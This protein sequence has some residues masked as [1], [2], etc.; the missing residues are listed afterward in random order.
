[1]C[2]ERPE[3]GQGR[4]DE[5]NDQSHDRCAHTQA[6]AVE[7]GAC[8]CDPDPISPGM[9]IY[10]HIFRASPA[11]WKHREI[12]EVTSILYMVRS[13]DHDDILSSRFEDEAPSC[14]GLF[15]K[16]LMAS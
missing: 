7:G 16:Q 1:M 5:Q 12:S 3:D 9:T 15:F 2:N 10:G 4:P 8:P 13:H 14:D 11:G 6:Q